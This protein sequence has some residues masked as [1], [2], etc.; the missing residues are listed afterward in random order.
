MYEMERTFSNMCKIRVIKNIKCISA[1]K[2]VKQFTKKQ[3]TV[4]TR[5]TYESSIS[6]E[7]RILTENILQ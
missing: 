1:P 3:I 7:F 2:I 6:L 5:L 4:I